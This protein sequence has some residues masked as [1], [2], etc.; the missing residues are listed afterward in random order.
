MIRHKKDHSMFYIGCTNDFERRIPEHHVRCKN[1][2]RSE[3]KFKVYVMIRENGGW[4]A[5]EIHIIDI[6]VTTDRD[7]LEEM[8]KQYILDLKP[9]MNTID[10]TPI[11]RKQ[12][13]RQYRIDNAEYI[14]N[15][16]KQYKIDNAENLRKQ[17]K[18]YRIDN[19]EDIRNRNKQYRINNRDKIIA[20]RAWKSISKQFREIMM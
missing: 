17:D 3:Y 10:Y 6:C 20:H 16:A 4:D 5:F 8:E 11:D 19:A 9:T 13:N 12:Y 2:N 7:I 14:R 18:Q 15:R 1:P